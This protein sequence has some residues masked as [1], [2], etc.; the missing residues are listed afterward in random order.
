M[1]PLFSGR[2]GTMHD[3]IVSA[4]RRQQSR[5]ATGISVVNG[6]L[7]SV[8]SAADTSFLFSNLRYLAQS[9]FIIAFEND[10]RSLV[11]TRARSVLLHSCSYVKE[12]SA[13][14]TDVG[15]LTLGLQIYKSRPSKTRRRTLPLIGTSIG[16]DYASGVP[17]LLNIIDV[18]KAQNILTRRHPIHKY[19]FNLLNLPA[20]T[21]PS[22]QSYKDWFFSED[23]E[24]VH[25]TFSVQHASTVDR[26]FPRATDFWAS[27][28]Y[29]LNA[30][31]LTPKTFA[32]INNMISGEREDAI[33]VLYEPKSA[34]YW[35]TR[36]QLASVSTRQSDDAS[37]PVEYA[38]ATFFSPDFSAQS[39]S[40]SVPTYYDCQV[41]PR[42]GQSLSIFSNARTVSV[43]TVIA[44]EY[45]QSINKLSGLHDGSLP[46]SNLTVLAPGLHSARITHNTFYEPSYETDTDTLV[47]LLDIDMWPHR[48]DLRIDTLNVVSEH[49]VIEIL[50]RHVQSEAFNF[51]I[52]IYVPHGLVQTNLVTCGI[53]T[54]D[55]KELVL[56]VQLE[57]KQILR[58]KQSNSS[59]K[60][61]Y[62]PDVWTAPSS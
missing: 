37:W 13:S 41:V 50:R 45:V 5:R 3:E 8:N 33:G 31:S 34:S 42:L 9:I 61:I 1:V 43:G 35:R 48:A 52:C 40:P 7:M 27:G 25:A 44:N 30:R 28:V 23:V 19:N 59:S 53:W 54:E 62:V 57:A 55:N 6:T 38:R 12:T 58:V 29:S 10:P 36:N 56:Q 39:Y 20:L 4:L 26:V 32:Y 15:V 11:Y 21:T 46:A 16:A 24:L 49:V 60:R 47:L 14:G 17:I 2:E 18:E 51:V 22:A